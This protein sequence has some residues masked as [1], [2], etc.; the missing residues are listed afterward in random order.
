[1]KNHHTGNE[2]IQEGTILRDY[3]FRDSHVV[4]PSGYREIGPC[5]FQD[6]LSLEW[7]SIPS[8]VQHIQEWAFWGCGNLK[9]V[10]LEAGLQTI[11]ES[12]F[13]QTFLQQIRL[14]ETLYYLGE[15]AFEDTLLETLSVPGG[16][17]NLYQDTFR[18][19]CCLHTVH[20]QAG[21]R[22]IYGG[23]F[24]W[25]H[26]LQD[27]YIPDSLEQIDRYAFEGS[28]PIANIHASARWL[29]EHSQYVQW[30]KEPL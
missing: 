25:C 6:N 21:I 28:T 9:T 27:L 5:A 20:L 13:A 3:P 26:C 1:M 11:G 23:A 12:A 19:N 16:I 17:P 15:G 30:L 7:I 10:L 18:G 2:R 22:R 29:Q 8:S 24:G 14:P 4:L